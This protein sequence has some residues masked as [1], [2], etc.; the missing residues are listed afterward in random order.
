[1]LRLTPPKS[2][3]TL[4]IYCLLLYVL[5][6]TVWDFLLGLPT[7]N[8][9]SPVL[10]MLAVVGYFYGKTYSALPARKAFLTAFYFVLPIFLLRLAPVLVT[11]DIPRNELGAFIAI[12]IGM[13]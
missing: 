6:S 2:P 10:L 12:S 1:M 9:K 3:L 5:I 4:A 8:S 7:E 13:I 11:P